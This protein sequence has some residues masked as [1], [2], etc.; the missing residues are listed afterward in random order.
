MRFSP[1][2]RKAALVQAGISM[3]EIAHQLGVS[4]SLVSHVVAGRKQTGPDARRVM[5][6]IARLV[7][8]P[9]HEVFPVLRD[10][11]A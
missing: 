4:G 9:V 10:E 5:G 2:L 6:E 1:N 3:T 11:A 7:G 8:R